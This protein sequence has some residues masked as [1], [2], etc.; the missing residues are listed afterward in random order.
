VTS[1][2]AALAPDPLLGLRGPLLLGFRRL[3][4]F[5]GG[6]GVCAR[7]LELDADGLSG[8]RARLAG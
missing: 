6:G 5:L 3:G 8:L 1:G 2:R 4:V 7:S